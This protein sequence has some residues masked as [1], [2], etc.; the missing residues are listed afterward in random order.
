MIPDPAPPYDVR[1]LGFAQQHIVDL[2][3]RARTLGMWASVSQQ[4][5]WAEEA[6]RMRP[7]QWGDP[8]RNLRA[9][10]Q[11]QYRSVMDDLIFYYAVHERLPEVLV[12]WVTAPNGHP[13]SGPNG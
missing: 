12:N 3:T 10:H 9:L 2:L 8:I 4:M 11:V 13:L 1:L 6:M 5:L 7:R